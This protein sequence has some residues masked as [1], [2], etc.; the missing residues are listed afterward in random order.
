MNRLSAIILA[1]GASRRMENKNKLLLPY[2][3]T[4]VLA[5]TAGNILSAGYTDV[6]VVTGH[7]AAAVQK[8]VRHLPVRCIN[9][10]QHEKG[11]TGSIQTGVREATGD[12]Y[13]ICLSDM[14]LITPEEYSLLQKAFE[15][16]YSQDQRCICLPE[17]RGTKGNP[18]IFSAF[19]RE[20]ILRHPEKEGCK[21]IVRA[22]P[23]H[24]YRVEMPSDSILKDM[25]DP[26]QYQSL[27]QEH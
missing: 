9:N 10:E 6:I 24:Q 13:M 3:G 12:G 25:D 21:G 27:L 11:M 4:T 19:Y 1:A 15:T 5:H 8:A 7:E 17:Y 14:V 18:V 20:A 16:R 22:H 26:E 2:R 23:Q